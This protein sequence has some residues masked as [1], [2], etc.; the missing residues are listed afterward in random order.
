MWAATNC[1]PDTAFMFWSKL[2]VDHFR[3]SS[4]S[5]PPADLFT[6]NFHR[7]IETVVKFSQRISSQPSTA[8][9]EFQKVLMLG[10]ADTKVGLYS[11]F[12]DNA[13]YKFGY[14]S[15]EAVRMAYM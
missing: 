8:Q 6:S 10:F 15:E 3:T 1:L 14:G 2:L 11:N 12:H 9:R 4:F 5:K 13:V 7:E